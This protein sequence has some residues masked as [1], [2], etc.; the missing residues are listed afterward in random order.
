[1][2]ERSVLLALKIDSSIRGFPV[3]F[4]TFEYT[5]NDV[6][7]SAPDVTLHDIGL[8]AFGTGIDSDPTRI[9][10][11]Q[12]LTD[13]VN[14]EPD[15]EI[16][17][18]IDKVRV[19]SGREPALEPIQEERQTVTYPEY[20]V[21]TPADE[22]LDLEGNIIKRVR[23]LSILRLASDQVSLLLDRGYEIVQKSGVSLDAFMAGIEDPIALASAPQSIINKQ[24]ITIFADGSTSPTN[25]GVFEMH[26][27]QVVMSA[28]DYINQVKKE[29]AVN[30]FVSIPLLQPLA[31]AAGTGGE[32][33]GLVLLIAAVALG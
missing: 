11:F 13:M 10:W 1:M 5:W 33:M 31:P 3:Y 25:D 29:Q 30:Q 8:F 21:L 18:L 26:D 9:Q 32:G 24:P 6:V 16:R 15:A 22:G 17:I 23:H 28:E 7:K 12:S 4:G 20:Y 27:A 2:V 19:A 14:Q